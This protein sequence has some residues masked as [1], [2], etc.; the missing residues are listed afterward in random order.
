MKSF[1]RTTV[2]SSALLSM[3]T[4]AVIAQ[5]NSDQDAVEPPRFIL[6]YSGDI[7]PFYGDINPFYGDINPFYGDISPF[8]GDI[9]PFWGDINPFYGDI[10][11]FYGDISPFWGDINPF[12]GDI[13][14]FYGD[15]NPF[16]G[17]I[18]PF[19][20]DL[21]AYWGDISP[22]GDGTAAMYADLVDQIDSMFD[23]AQRVFGTAIEDGSGGSYDEFKAELLAR[24]GI[25]LSDP[26]SLEHVT[27]EQ[28]AA[29]F[30]G[31][32]DGLMSYSGMDHVDHW[33]PTINWSPALSQAANAGN[34]TIV[35]L[36]DFSFAN[37]DGLNVRTSSGERD[38][39][40]FNHGA[41]VAGLI[42]AP[43]DGTGVMGVAPNVV[44]R[45]YNPFDDTLTTNWAEIA[46][47]MWSLIHG[48]AK[49]INISLGQPGWT[50]HQD[51]ATI[52]SD[53]YI[54][55]DA[56]ETVLV[57]AA[58]NDGLAQTVDL[59]WTAVADD[60]TNV[61]NV[62]NLLIVGSVNPNGEISSFSNRPGTACLLVNG[63]CQDGF[64]LM[65]RFLV[66]PGE[67]ILVSDGEGGVVR[68]SGT[69]FA[70]PLVTGASAL[71]QGR[72]GWL[73]ARDVTDVLLMSAR[74]L[75]APGTDEVY[76]RGL[77]DVGAAM[78]PL[79][80]DNLF[81]VDL[82]QKKKIR[83]FGLRS[84]QLTFQTRGD[85]TLT[86]FEKLND[87]VRDF[88]VSLDD[89]ELDPN[90]S[91][92]EA[93]AA[94][95]TYLYEQTASFA[96]TSF[97]N[98]AEY[99]QVLSQHGNLQ[100]SAVA[101]PADPRDQITGGEFPFQASF[102]IV[103]T[104]TDRE[105]RFG[106]GEGALALN[107]QEGFGMFSDHRPETGG[108]NPVLGFAS[109]GAYA[110]TGVRLGEA[111]RMSVAVTSVRDEDMFVMPFSG[112]EISLYKGLDA[113]TATAFLAD[114]SHELSDRV[115]VHAS[116][117]YLH[118]DAGL[119]GAQGGGSLS[120][121]GGSQTSAVTLGAEA[122]LPLNLTLSTSA[123]IAQ[124][125]AASFDSGILSMP[126]HAYSTAFQLTARRDGVFSSH[127]AV[128]LSVIQPLYVEDG[129]LEYT[130]ASVGDRETGELT[131]DT[132][133][134]EL[135]GQRPLIAE[136]LYA[137]PLFGDHADLSVFTRAELS[138]GSFDQQSDNLTSGARFKITF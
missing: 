83:G 103:D 80:V 66:A 17:D 7:N 56:L 41:A 73:T 44:L 27:D 25:D 40:N 21:S 128:R 91:V 77:L 116:Y 10:N 52:L 84:G 4:G 36:L 62:S 43:Y 78:S 90:F 129:A 99:S 59:D 115:S 121:D 60:W 6:P 31:F 46:D 70:A 42:A 85:N 117:T 34:G 112:E 101:A 81:V 113:Y 98:T 8:W 110:M 137:T 45:T 72:W 88:V 138:D 104:A 18:G 74:D 67:L 133:T 93:E 86:L 37:E 132:Q 109:G 131:F 122:N 76:G 35:G 16:W 96:G 30:L 124:T 12:R 11:P 2:A 82:N 3:M 120:F 118:E 105:L 65:D 19:W 130:A 68:Q 134:W 61:S 97:N 33:M 108:V 55:N 114:V 53:W 48:G 111:T 102:S 95:E 94:A 51:W 71:V 89:L 125:R 26:A 13:N 15:I 20:G 5:D 9:S 39:F 47:G 123:T 57:F 87:T 14:P 32:Y 119:L 28:R 69:S 64:R 75:G 100:I 24:Y 92:E 127:D 54:A 63:V 49:T 58:G 79:D 29:F 126:D 107:N 38:H 22:F 136:M 135:G 23:D 50:L 106:S 1:L